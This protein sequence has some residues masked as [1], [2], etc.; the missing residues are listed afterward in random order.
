[1]VLLDMNFAPIGFIIERVCRDPMLPSNFSVFLFARMYCV[2]IL[3]QMNIG[4]AGP[5]PANL[6][7]P[8]YTEDQNTELGWGGAAS[9]S[10]GPHSAVDAGAAASPAVSN[11]MCLPGA[12]AEFGV[13]APDFASIEEGEEKAGL[14]FSAVVAPAAASADVIP[15]PFSASHPC[16]PSYE[17]YV[18]LLT[19]I[20]DMCETR[21][22]RQHQLRFS[23]DPA[24]LLLLWH[25][26]PSDS[27]GIKAVLDQWLGPLISNVA[28]L[29][30][31]SRKVFYQLTLPQW[32]QFTKSFEPMQT[33]SCGVFRH[34]GFTALSPVRSLAL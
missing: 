33:L 14:S 4:S 23:C 25:I 16:Y 15:Q 21:P 27:V 9:G 34:T 30:K 13:A 17:R 12:D 20:R 28:S 10:S 2:F 19:Q 32:E 3:F 5:V 1:V 24:L 26:C 6:S 7:S 22:M 8:F 31:E 11:S 29:P 18:N